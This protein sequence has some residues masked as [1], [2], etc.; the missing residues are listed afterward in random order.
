MTSLKQPLYQ[1]KAKG[2]VV[3]VIRKQ[4]GKARLLLLMLRFRK[5]ALK[6][7][8][9]KSF[10]FP[11]CEVFMTGVKFVKRKMFVFGRAILIQYLR[12]VVSGEDT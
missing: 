7:F 4:K 9:R 6:Q 11:S 10:I 8:S 3:Q 12:K 5:Y 2:C 1:G